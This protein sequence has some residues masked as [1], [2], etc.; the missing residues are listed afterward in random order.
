MPKIKYPEHIQ[1]LKEQLETGN[2]LVD[3]FFISGISP[4]LCTNELLYKITSEEKNSEIL[5]DILQPK[6]LCKFPDFDKTNV[7]IDEGIIDYCFPDGFNIE[8]NDKSYPAPKYF[9]IVLDN[10]MFSQ[11]KPQKY[12][13]CALIYESLH[14][15]KKLKQYIKNIESNKE[16]NGQENKIID[17]INNLRNDLEEEKNTNI[18]RHKKMITNITPLM[19]IECMKMD[20]QDLNGINMDNNIYLEKNKENKNKLEHYYI[21]KCICLVSTH[22]NVKLYQ[23]ILSNIIEYG[24]SQNNDIEIPLEKIITNLIIEVPVPP[25]GLY[26]I[27]YDYNFDFS[28]KNNE[29]NNESLNNNETSVPPLKS[30]E[31]NKLLLSDI[32]L[33]KFNKSLSF[34]CKIETL[35]HILLGTKILFFSLNLTTII[36]TI[37]AFMSLIFPFKYPFQILSYLHKQNYGILESPSIFI[38]GIR[39]KFDENFFKIN[40]I[41]LEF[42]N[43]FVVDLDSKDEKNYYLFTEEEFPKFP[44]KLLSNLEKEIKS[45][46]NS[47]IKTIKEF[48]ENYQEKFFKFVCEILRGYEEFL[49]RDFFNDNFVDVST[50]F[51]CEK[52]IKCIYHSQADYPFYKK[53]IEESQL[54]QEFI[55]KNM[56]PKNN[57]ELMDILFVSNYLNSQKKKKNKTN[58]K[59]DY[60]ITNKYIVPRPKEITKEEGEQIIKDRLSLIKKGQIIKTSKSKDENIIK[61]DYI[62]FPELDFNIYCNNDNVNQ[63]ISPPDYREEIEALNMEAISKSS[64]GKN[65]NRAME[66]K[67]YLYLTW[68]EIWAFTFGNNDLKERH[69]RF[70]QMLDVLDK[71]IHHEMN[72]L[73]LMFN[74]LKEFKENEMLLKLYQKILQLKIKPSFLIFDIMK[75]IIDK[76]NMLN[77][78]D[79]TKK[80]DKKL[81]SLKFNDYNKMNNRERTFLSINDNLPLETKPKFYFDYECINI[82]CF[83]KINLYKISK[84]FE[85]VRNDIL[86]VPCSKCKEFTLPKITVKFGLNFLTKSSSIEEYVLHSPYNLKTNIKQAFNTQLRNENQNEKFKLKI[87]NFKAQFQP[88]FWDFIWYCIIHDLDYNIL[89]PYSKTL[90]EEKKSHYTN[91]N[92]KIFEISYDDSTFVDNQN[93]ILK[94]SSN[95]IKLNSGEKSKKIKFKKLKKCNGVIR[96]E[97]KDKKINILLNSE[98]IEEKEDDNNFSEEDIKDNN[99]NNEKSNEKKS[100]DNDNSKHKKSSMFDFFFKV[101]QKID[102]IKN[103]IKNNKEDNKIKEEKDKS[104]EKDEIKEVKEDNIDVGL[105]GEEYIDD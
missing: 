9:S 38:F 61:F 20:K 93:K 25:R 78:L 3:Y 35:E 39:E 4:S 50:L 8:Y 89:L 6:I 34:N 79:E 43:F 72:I 40:D 55:L 84:T 17:N 42:Q 105:L 11:D 82:D 104:K 29:I 71:V 92:I 69:Y 23:K 45:L 77:I 90:E 5:K 49:N 54:F 60:T 13:I 64:L 102:Q 1:K 46:E 2:N 24:L 86:W 22:P 67:N 63:Y 15:Y 101:N 31:N 37:S 95:I 18:Y 28:K 59:D 80:T 14:K 98:I 85:G 76:E 30:T 91:P 73:N 16:D 36:D 7:T 62:L 56:T 51:N 53:F 70:D 96:L 97:I 58:E 88:L 94:I 21:P 41:H 81:K 33:N 32:D 83:E 19:D 100:V 99:K 74:M 27:H 48:N 75:N 44:S 47:K 103:E 66:M 10:S 57:N 12:L 68:L 26:S 52:F 65:I 87:S